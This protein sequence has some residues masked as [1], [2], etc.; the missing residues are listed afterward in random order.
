MTRLTSKLVLALLLLCPSW[1]Q[2]EWVKL[3]ETESG[4]ELFIEDRSIRRNGDIAYALTLNVSSKNLK[5]DKVTYKTVA[6]SQR[7]DCN[8]KQTETINFFLMDE[9]G[10]SGKLV[11]WDVVEENWIPAV[12]NA[13]NGTLLNYVCK[14]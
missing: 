4:K 9:K 6:S 14:R 1:A 2:A 11:G 3:A 5:A 10:L 13:V 12:E 8:K 7:F